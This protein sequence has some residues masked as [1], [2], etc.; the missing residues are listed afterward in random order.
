[1]SNFKKITRHPVTG[2]LKIAEWLDDY[3][4]PHEYGVRFE[5]NT[6]VYREEDVDVNLAKLTKQ[7]KEMK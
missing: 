7:R 6:K 2:L 3:F 4:G 1:M 5:G